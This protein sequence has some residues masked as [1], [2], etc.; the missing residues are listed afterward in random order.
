MPIKSY[1]RSEGRRPAPKMEGERSGCEWAV[2]GFL[3]AALVFAPWA[4][5]GRS[6]WAQAILLGL[7]GIAF[8]F[9]TLPRRSVLTGGTE[10]SVEV[11]AYGWTRLRRFPP[12][13]LGLVFAIYVGVSACNPSWRLITTDLLWYIRSEGHVAWLPSSVAAP[14]A[15]MN[16]WRMLVISGSVWFG[17]CAVWAGITR[18]DSLLLL[19]N[20]FI[21]HGTAFALVA[22][23]QKV[24]RAKEILW[25]IKSP[26]PT[27][28]GTFVY[29]NH[30]AAYLNLV[31]ITAFGVAFWR[32][33]RGV[34]RLEKSTPAPLYAFAGLV[35]VCALLMGGSRAGTLLWLG[36][37]GVAG[38]IFLG[39]QIFFNRTGSRALSIVLGVLVIG[40]VA[41]AGTFLNLKKGI[42]SATELFKSQARA[43]VEFRITARQATWEMFEAKPWTGWGAGSFRHAFPLFQQHHPSIFKRGKKNLYWDHAH[44]DYVQLLAEVGLVGAVLPVLG[45]FWLMWRFFST[46]GLRNPGLAIFFGGLLL[47]LL[48]AWVDF[49][50]YNAAVLL[51]F[52]LLLTVLVRW[53]ELTEEIRHQA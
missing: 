46:G 29:D 49:P 19:L 30:A 11:P 42:F 43:D 13:W 35:A 53:S 2:L 38:S 10:G 24:T 45:L 31:L 32:Y 4:I 36:Y 12:F 7:C 52:G 27:F 47:P 6:V 26:A 37:A 22:I 20:G 3:L 44:N 21:V 28:H 50:L 18:R 23:L 9:A 33:V 48:H 17:I 25:F 5:G 1:P 8:V 16:A 41:V 40:F 34:K 14:Y 51:T 39:W 15:K